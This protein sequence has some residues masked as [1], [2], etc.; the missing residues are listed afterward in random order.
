MSEMISRIR[1]VV[2]GT[3]AAAFAIAAVGG[4]GASIVSASHHGSTAQSSV[5]SARSGWGS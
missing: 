3:A 2:V 1:R 4:T 5:I